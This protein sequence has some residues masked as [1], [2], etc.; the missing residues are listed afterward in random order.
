M[1]PQATI[2]Y[3]T[4]VEVYHRSIAWNRVPL[5]LSRVFGLSSPVPDGSIGYPTL[6]KDKTSAIIETPRESD[7]EDPLGRQVLEYIL[8]TS[9]AEMLPLNF[10]TNTTLDVHDVL[11]FEYQRKDGQTEEEV[12]RNQSHNVGHFKVGTD[13]PGTRAQANQKRH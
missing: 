8:K 1:W 10:T 3:V 5:S 9:Y 11:L 13:R 6:G 7:S 4:P 2:S 12:S